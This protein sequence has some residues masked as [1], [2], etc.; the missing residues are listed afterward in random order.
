M[1]Q[2]GNGN[3]LLFSFRREVREEST[4]I[5]VGPVVV[6][7]CEDLN[8]VLSLDRIPGGINKA[9]LA[10]VGA[11]EHEI[12]IFNVVD[13]RQ[14]GTAVIVVKDVAFFI[15]LLEV[16]T[17]AVVDDFHAGVAQCI[18]AGFKEVIVREGAV[19]GI[20]CAARVG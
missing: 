5:R 16:C 15:N 7:V 8:H 12:F 11:F 13:S 3:P 6:A 9:L 18:V 14:F 4:V 1:A 17:E 10:G 2:T 20:V 19:V